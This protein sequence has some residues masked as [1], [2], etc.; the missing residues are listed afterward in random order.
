MKI[1]KRAIGT[2]IALV[3]GLG[4]A[5]FP[6]TAANA[7]VPTCNG[8]SNFALQS[9]P[10]PGG[11]FPS[12]HTSPKTRSCN[13]WPGGNQ[14]ATRA[15]QESLNACNGAS[16]VVDGAYGPATQQ[17]VRNVQSRAGIAVDGVYGPQTMNAMRWHNS[18]GCYSAGSY[19]TAGH[20]G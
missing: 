16:L 3:I 2:T 10:G 20:N 18:V 6:T 11:G 7:A 19:S 8:S 5:A 12:F 1:V 9:P 4:M 17:A 14:Y 15:L 13:L